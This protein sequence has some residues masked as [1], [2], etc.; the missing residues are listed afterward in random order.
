MYT[1]DLLLQ[2]WNPSPE[3]SSFRDQILTFLRN[4]PAPFDRET[5]EGH[6][7][8]S[9]FILHPDRRHILMTYHRKLEEWLTLG[10]HADGDSDV[11][12]VAHREAFEESG[13][14]SEDIVLEIPE[15][16]SI[17]IHTIPEYQ[18]VPEHLHYDVSFVFRAKQTNIQISEESLDLA[19]VPLSQV[20]EKT[21]TPR[22][23]R[24]VERLQLHLQ[25]VA[26][27]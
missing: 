7:T 18:G 16:F 26:V 1:F 27:E 9:A 25:R 21:K 17:D 20:A 15:I 5:L 6:I 23:L 24:G 11:L 4:S 3:E 19:W 12:R 8:G 10:G 13:L 14:A 2:N 22:I